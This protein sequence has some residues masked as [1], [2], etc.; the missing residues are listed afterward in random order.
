M[1]A[2]AR[3]LPPLLLR[4]DCLARLRDLPDDSIDAVV[5]SP[6][7]FGL[8]DYGHDGQLGAET[9][10]ML[11]K[12]AR[13]HYDAAAVAEPVAASTVARMA[14]GRAPRMGGAKYGESVATETCTKSGA[15]YSG[16][17]TR[18]RRTVWNIATAASGGAH[19]AVMPLE[20]ARICVRASTPEGGV[21]LDP[22]AG[23]GTTLE[24]AHL[25]GFEAIG[26]ELTPEYWPL[27]EARIRRAVETRAKGGDRA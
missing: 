8:R 19:F 26:V 13:Y 3:P 27:I 6:P 2:A 17:D 1:S 20:L 25:E 23:S 10:F 14:T 21:V 5:T 9:V 4:G 12:T 7:Y 16:G 24:A 22:F 18:R 15:A 11:T